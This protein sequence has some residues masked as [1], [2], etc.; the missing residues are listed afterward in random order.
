MVG[1]PEVDLNRT[2]VQYI[3]GSL[4]TTEDVYCSLNEGKCLFIYSPISLP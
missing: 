1:Y 2:K 3:I 4:Q